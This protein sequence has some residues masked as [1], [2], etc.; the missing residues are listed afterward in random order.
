MAA[1]V[2]VVEL[3]SVGTVLAFDVLD[4][5]ISAG[6]GQL[7]ALGLADVRFDSQMLILVTLHRVIFDPITTKI[8]QRPAFLIW[9]RSIL[10][11]SPVLLRSL[12]LLIENL[13]FLPLFVRPRHNPYS[14]LLR[15][16]DG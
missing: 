6:E 9:I 5:Q 11:P 16:F 13:L 14:F 8:T 12:A 2:A 3:W 15:R 7:A 1:D 10:P 4:Q